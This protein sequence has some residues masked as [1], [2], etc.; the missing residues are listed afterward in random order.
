[1]RARVHAQ[2]FLRMCGVDVRRP[3]RILLTRPDRQLTLTIDHLIARR[4]LDR[5]DLFF[6]QIGAFDGK[7]GDQIHSYVLRYHW[8]GILVEPHP[9]SFAALKDT[10]GGL[11]RLQL[12]NVAV[13]DE[14]GTRSLYAVRDDAE[15]L[16]EWAPQIASFDRDRLLQTG[17]PVEEHRVECLPLEALLA[18]VEHI[19]LLQVDV[20]G[21]DAEVIRM[22]DFDR[23]RPSIVRFEN[24][25]LSRADH[26]AATE[27]LVSYG[28]RVAVTGA[29][30]VGWY[31]QEAGPEG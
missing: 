25:A 17:F 7:T 8:H 22:F 11:E 3:P 18:D 31:G 6:M 13:S 10:Y 24:V 15:G 21:Y 26:D 19:D 1:M 14:P 5:T 9:R 12:R 20:E 23:Y 2:R 27:R 29:D 16:P 30:T 28:Y 4:L